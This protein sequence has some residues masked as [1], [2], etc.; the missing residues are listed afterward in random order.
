MT[1]F[2]DRI[3]S[4]PLYGDE[5]SFEFKSWI[6]VLIDSQNQ[7]IEEI[8]GLFNNFVLQS[9]TQADILAAFAAGSPDGSMW[10][11]YNSTP[12]N[13]VVQINGALRQLTTTAFP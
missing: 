10:Y 11:C 5:F 4:A 7:N 3:D 13:V 9:F 2:L 1:I 12:P 8:E 6:S